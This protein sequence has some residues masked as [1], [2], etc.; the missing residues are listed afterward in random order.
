MNLTF[1]PAE[2]SDLSTVLSWVP[3]AEACIIWA[4]PKIRYPAVAE[5]AWLDIEASRENTFS[6]VKTGGD[7]VGFGQA[8]LRECC[9]V[10]LARIIVDPA[11]RGRGYGRLLC[12]RLMEVAEKRIPV[13]RFTLNV[14]KTNKAAI[15]LYRSL[16]FAK[17][18]QQ[19]SEDALFMSMPTNNSVK[20]DRLSHCRSR[21]GR[22]R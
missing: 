11:L 8:M 21:T 7:L 1:R 12:L 5:S 22:L 6:L 20:T 4:G 2:I 9:V 19:D 16:G 3:D 13:R 10:H 15:S 17:Q 14:Y 18:E